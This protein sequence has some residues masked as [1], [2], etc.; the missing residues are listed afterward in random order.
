ML[1]MGFAPAIRINT[2]V[3]MNV[4]TMA[5][6]GM[7]ALNQPGAGARMRRYLSFM[8]P[9]PSPRSSSTQNFLGGIIAGQD[10]HN[11]SFID[12]CNAVRKAANSSRSSEISS[13]AAP[14][15]RCSISL[16]RTYSVA[17]TS[18][19]RVGCEAMIMRVGVERAGK[20]HFLHVPARKFAGLD[21]GSGFDLI[22]LDHGF[23]VRFDL[24]PVQHA[25]FKE[26]VQV[27][28]ASFRQRSFRLQPHRGDLPG[29]AQR[30]PL[31][32]IA[33]RSR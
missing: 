19:P 8:R 18:N 32:W 2:E 30:R 13:T 15:S 12:H 33:G 9:P 11:S 17:P 7:S 28:R 5:S 31:R 23:G 20:D 27:S 6:T 22:F 26:L 25:I 1:R 10:P 21:G 3:I 29:C 14:R 4:T 16:L 24:F